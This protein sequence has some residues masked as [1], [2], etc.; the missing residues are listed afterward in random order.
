MSIKDISGN[1]EVTIDANSP[2][3]AELE[4]RAALMHEPEFPDRCGGRNLFNG[5]NPAD[6]DTLL[7]I[8]F[9]RDQENLVARRWQSHHSPPVPNPL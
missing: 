8:A 6:N 3:V 5:E 9:L 4:R 7:A 1:M 2:I